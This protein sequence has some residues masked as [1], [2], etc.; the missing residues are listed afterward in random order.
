[1][2]VVHLSIHEKRLSE[3]L[4]VGIGLLGICIGC[5]L[6]NAAEL[7]SS[8]AIPVEFTRTIDAGKMISGTRVVAKTMQIVHL[9]GG[10]V[11]PRG[12]TVLGHVV[13]SRP[14]RFDPAPYAVQQPSYI[15]I[16]IDKI[17]TKGLEI[18][19][20][21]S[22]RALASTFA[23]NDA[24]TPHPLDETDSAPRTVQVGGDQ[25][26]RVSKDISSRDGETVGYI[27]GQ[28]AFARL[29]SNSYVS[30]YASLQCDS[31]STEQSV[32][33]FSASACGLY[34][35]DSTYMPANGRNDHGT[36]K[37]ESRH[38][39]VKLYAGSAALIEIDETKP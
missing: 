2:R 3:R 35:F 26:S 36:F 21:A 37:I 14:F 5:R 23:V 4:S 29:I 39:T 38:H 8:T 32:A 7:P 24:T 15:S 13:D 28:G 20:N 12:A 33:I 1:M 10:K 17:V 18:P 27:R 30:R 34:G 11:I 22:V 16:H 9:S 19:M 25:Y 31:T 6:S